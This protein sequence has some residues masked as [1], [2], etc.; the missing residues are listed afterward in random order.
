MNKVELRALYLERRT[1]LSDA[2][3]ALLNSQ[4]HHTFFADIDLSWVKT[5]HTF[6]PLKKNKE[7][8]TWPVIHRIQ[9]E[10]PQIRIAIPKVDA[11]TSTLENFIF[12]GPHQIRENKW[13]IPEPRDGEHVDNATIDMVLVPLLVVDNRGNRVGYGKGFYD[14][15]LP[16]CRKDCKRVGISLFDPLESISD[17]NSLDVPLQY[18]VTP[19]QVF[20][21]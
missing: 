21:F 18:C 7:P 9:K 4:W 20:R 19:N 6:L 8:D 1:S 11:E 10:F 2:E 16:T 3:Y 15:F 12:D 13:G 5:L 17:V 14:K